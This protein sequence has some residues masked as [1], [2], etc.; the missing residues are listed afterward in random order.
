MAKK[1]KSRQTN[2]AARQ[3]AP[4]PTESDVGRVV[5]VRRQLEQAAFALL[6]AAMLIVPLVF[7]TATLE[8]SSHIKTL[9]IALAM[10]AVFSLWLFANAVENRF[11]LRKPRLNIPVAAYLFVCV[12]ASIAAFNRPNSLSLL[13][14]LLWCMAVYVVVANS[15]Y[16]DDAFL[17]VAVAITIAA[18]LAA[19]YGTLQRFNM[20]FVH[21]EAPDGE[22]IGTPSTFGHRNFAAEYMVAALPFVTALFFRLRNNIGKAGVL[23]AVL[24]I[25]L[26][27][28]LA[29]SRA[30]WI[31]VLSAAAFCIIAIAVA[32]WRSL[33]HARRREL[34]D[35]FGK[36]FRG[37][38]LRVV[39][40]CA[41]VFFV[42][43]PFMLRSDFRDFV[44]DVRTT[45]SLER[46]SN[47]I[48]LA[49]WQSSAH[50]A[51]AHPVLGVGFGNYE[52][53]LPEHWNLV[54]KQRFAEKNMLSDKAH[55]AYLQIA[56]ETGFLGLAAFT[57]VLAT[58]FVVGL[59][60]VT[61][62]FPRQAHGFV[63]AALCSIVAALVNGFLAFNLIN[64]ATRMLFWFS[65]GCLG[66]AERCYSQVGE[67]NRGNTT[68]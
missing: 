16:R 18:F 49:T 14:N 38:E 35:A 46:E 12:A 64:P 34:F 39:A 36:Y 22:Q 31:A 20:D 53:F 19:G 21:W 56:C 50:L 41:V 65:L 42:V 8:A 60:L 66:A 6:T 4:Q 63:L 68:A 15:D 10:F 67:R 27:L 17:A 52:V 29:G 40:G 44:K 57:W 37:W 3:A 25:L 45:F 48:R 23:L 1:K 54:D 61:G 30:S 11:S 7:S 59:R 26:Q 58:A 24:V 62:G 32:T 55:N 51:L 5:A 2:T 47:L 43:G 28:F 9:V 13:H 33:G